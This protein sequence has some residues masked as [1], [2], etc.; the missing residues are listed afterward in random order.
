MESQYNDIDLWKTTIDSF[1]FSHIQQ[2][3]GF[4]TKKKKNDVETHD[5]ILCELSIQQY[6]IWRA[7][8]SGVKFVQNNF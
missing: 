6:A 2:K 1:N 5:G 7:E 3:S 8:F 4:I